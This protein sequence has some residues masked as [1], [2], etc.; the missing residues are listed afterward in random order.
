MPERLTPSFH[1]KSLL[2]PIDVLQQSVGIGVT[3]CGIHHHGFGNYRAEGRRSRG[4]HEMEK[5]AQ[6]INVRAL[7][8]IALWSAKS[9]RARDGLHA[10]IHDVDL[11]ELADHDVLRFEIPVNHASAV[12][13]CERLTDP[14]EY[15]Q[16]LGEGR[17]AGEVAVQAFTLHQFHC[18]K[19]STVGKR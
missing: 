4:K 10:P 18:V 14:S 2:E 1:G 6:S 19:C 11:A 13:E 8:E 3:R 12:R 9:R 15:A 7:I 17:N 5:R 16:A